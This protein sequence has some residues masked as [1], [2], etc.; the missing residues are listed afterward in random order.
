L[1]IVDSEKLVSHGSYS[2]RLILQSCQTEITFLLTGEKKEPIL[3]EL[4][5]E[6]WL[7]SEP[8]DY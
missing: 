1:L 7:S 6:L 4:P 8:G 5:R 2:I 3:P